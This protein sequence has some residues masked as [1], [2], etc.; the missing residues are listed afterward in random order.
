LE[1]TA[2]C[3][4]DFVRYKIIKV[5]LL[6]YLHVLTRVRAT[7]ITVTDIRK[8]LGRTLTTRAEVSNKE[9]LSSET[10]VSLEVTKTVVS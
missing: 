9:R 6:T 1:I 8:R 7:D 10:G 5:H 2:H 3:D 4:Y